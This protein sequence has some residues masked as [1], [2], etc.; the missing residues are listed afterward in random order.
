MVNGRPIFRRTLDIHLAE[1]D[2]LGLGS[3]L[4]E[5]A[6]Q[7]LIDSELLTQAAQRAGIVVTDEEVSAAIKAGLVEPLSDP[8][9]PDDVVDLLTANLQAQGVPVGSVLSDARVRD[10]YHGLIARGRYLAA[11]GKSRAEVLKELREASTITTRK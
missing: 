10:A 11:V 4:P 5:D 9:T 8:A 3:Q 6:L 7:D 2:L 1:A